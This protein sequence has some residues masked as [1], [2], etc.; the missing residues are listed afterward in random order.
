[1]PADIGGAPL[2]QPPAVSTALPVLSWP[3]G[4][5]DQSQQEPIAMDATTQALAL[6]LLLSTSLPL[7]PPGWQIAPDPATGKVYFFNAVTGVVQW[8]Q[9]QQA[10]VP[11]QTQGAAVAEEGCDPESS[12]A[13]MVNLPDGSGDTGKCTLATPSASSGTPP[14]AGDQDHVEKWLV[15]GQCKQPRVSGH[16]CNSD[17]CCARRAER[18]RIRPGSVTGPGESLSASTPP[19]G[20]LSLA[21]ARGTKPPQAAAAPVPKATDEDLIVGAKRAASDGDSLG[22]KQRRLGGTGGE[23]GP[24][25]P[26]SC[27]HQ[28]KSVGTNICPHLRQK[29][30]C[31]DCGGKSLCPHGRQRS[32]CR[33]CG[34][35]SICEHNRRRNTCKQ[36]GGASLCEHKRQRSQCKECGGA[37]VCEHKR[38]RNKCK[39]CRGA[40]FC[41]HNRQRSRC[42][43]CGG[44]SFCQH[45]KRKDKCKECKK[46]RDALKVQDNDANLPQKADGD[47]KMLA[48]GNAAADS[49]LVLLLRTSLPASSCDA[50]AGNPPLPLEPKTA[51]MESEGRAHEAKAAPPPPPLTPHGMI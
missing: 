9:P 43:L 17:A 39:D 1:M 4:E 19:V 46:E 48:L 29:N 42:K 38:Q 11:P 20:A 21:D 35:K 22:V 26:G 23:G 18:S 32:E 44:S 16:R 45:D 14:P 41:E 7:L 27:P 3:G 51:V 2:A 8:E 13:S 10:S 37:S 50:T 6:S 49:P 12:V 36:C 24:K 34:G 28:R 15:C 47:N 33:D 5:A 30:K 25:R 40:S 31:K